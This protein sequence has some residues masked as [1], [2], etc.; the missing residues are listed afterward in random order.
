[1]IVVMFV[2][3]LALSS[4]LIKVWITEDPATQRET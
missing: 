3:A 1:M 2:L 4:V